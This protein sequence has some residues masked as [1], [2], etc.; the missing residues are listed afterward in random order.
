ML[1]KAN[2]WNNETFSVELAEEDKR[3]AYDDSDIARL[4]D[5]L[6]TQELWHYKPPKPERFWVVLI[7]LFHGLR[8]SNI[9]G[10][11]KRRLNP[12]PQDGALKSTP[13]GC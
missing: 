4:V 13:Q 9:T 6:C 2:K 8:L 10:L 11:S 1:D 12:R 5:A 7:A 3:Q